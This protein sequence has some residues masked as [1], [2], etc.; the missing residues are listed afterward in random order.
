MTGSNS[1]TGGATVSSGTLNAGSQSNT[2]APLLPTTSGPVAKT[3]TGTLTLTSPNIQFFDSMV[4]SGVSMVT[5][6]K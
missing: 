2:P 4:N 3:G 1:Y 6:H 5:L